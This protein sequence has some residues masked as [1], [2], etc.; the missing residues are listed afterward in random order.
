MLL[1]INFA[2]YKKC[3]V[4]ILWCTNI[5]TYIFCDIYKC[6]IYILLCINFVP[7]NFCNYKLQKIVSFVTEKKSGVKICKQW[8]HFYLCCS[9]FTHISIV[10]ISVDIS[11]SMESIGSH[12][13]TST[14]EN[15]SC[16]A[17][18]RG[19]QISFIVWATIASR[20]TYQLPARKLHPIPFACYSRCSC[21]QI[22]QHCWRLLSTILAGFEGVDQTRY[23]VEL[24]DQ[25]RKTVRAWTQKKVISKYGKW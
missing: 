19:R 9:G 8:P 23:F 6:Y 25:F 3:N 1:H 24:Q 17:Q 10:F 2:T 16:L 13:N 12:P 21:V 7:Y 14:T 11:S 18:D 20:K 4:C 22:I 5:V 15:S